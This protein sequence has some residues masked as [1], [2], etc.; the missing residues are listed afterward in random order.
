MGDFHED[1]VHREKRAVPCWN[2]E[3]TDRSEVSE[4]L[5]RVWTIPDCVAEDNE[6][7][8]VSLKSLK[9]YSEENLSQQQ[10]DAEKGQN[11]SIPQNPNEVTQFK[12]I[13]HEQLVE[14]QQAALRSKFEEWLTEQKTAYK[15]R[16]CMVL[17][18]KKSSRTCAEY[19]GVPSWSW[20]R[21]WRWRGESC[22][23]QESGSNGQK[24]HLKHSN[25][26]QSQRRR[27]WLRCTRSG[28]TVSKFKQ[29]KTQ[30]LTRTLH[31]DG[32]QDAWNGHTQVASQASTWRV[33]AR[34]RTPRSQKSNEAILTA[35]DVEKSVIE[36]NKQGGGWKVVSIRRESINDGT[37]SIFARAISAQT[38]HCVRVW[39]VCSF[40]FSFAYFV[41]RF[42]GRKGW[43]TIP[44]AGG[45]GASRSRTTS[46]RPRAPKDGKSQQQRQPGASAARQWSSGRSH[47]HQR[48]GRHTPRRKWPWHKS[49]F[50]C[51]RRHS[52][53]WGTTTTQLPTSERRWREPVNKQCLCQLQTRLHNARVSWNGQGSGKQPPE[54]CCCK[55]RQSW[56]GWVQRSSKGSNGWR[57]F[58]PSWSVPQSPVVAV[59]MSAEV[60]RLRVLVEQLSTEN[61][62]VRFRTEP[63]RTKPHRWC[64]VPLRVWASWML[65]PHHSGK[66][67]QVSTSLQM[68]PNVGRS[69]DST[70]WWTGPTHID[71]W[72]FSKLFGHLGAMVYVQKFRPNTPNNVVDVC[73]CSAGF[74]SHRHLCGVRYDGE[75]PA[76]ACVWPVGFGWGRR[77]GH[78]FT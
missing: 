67:T 23:D 78:T 22:K 51:W 16:H 56:H 48:S 35:T 73:S 46:Q 61:E 52:E 55:P 14:K 36:R 32:K 45:V 18:C 7:S 9:T 64:L 12:Q 49:A 24:F 8:N 27:R 70:V 62:D 43:S 47:R 33:R 10:V 75:G 41:S 25:I 44:V 26:D 6:V 60:Q 57:R 1:P 69:K 74:T 71:W 59:D 20:D 38:L 21:V 40:V 28:K 65:W 54:S 17:F 37:R 4:G 34:R 63:N 66:S 11:I 30:E 58:A 3:V 31:E 68:R 50:P 5:T 2:S 29:Q 13:D 72:G 15:K 42:M 19:F 39:W 53:L 77:A 76:R